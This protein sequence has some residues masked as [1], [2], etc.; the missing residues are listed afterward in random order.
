MNSEPE[1]L[2]RVPCPPGHYWRQFRIRVLP[3]L[4]F[5]GVLAITIWLWG[6]NL[7]NPLIV[8]QAESPQ[9]DVAS[10]KPGRILKLNVVLF[11][12]VKVGDVVAVIEIADPLVTSNTVAKILADMNLI[13]LSAGLDSAGRVSLADI[14]LKWMIQRADLAIA[15]ARFKWAQAQYERVSD[16]VA[17]KI[18]SPSLL[19]L[20]QRDRDEVAAEIE[21][22]TLAVKVADETFHAL[23]P[24]TADLESPVMK[25]TL[26]VAEQGLR[27]AEAQLAP[28][29]LTAPMAG[30]ISVLDKLTGS[31]VLAGAPIAT[32]SSSTPDRI[33]GFLGQPLR[34]DPKIGMKVEVRSRGLE[35]RTGAAQVLNIGPRVAL[36][37]ASVRVRGMGP[38]QERGLPVV[39]SVPPNM[40]LRPGELVDLRLV[41]N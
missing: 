17:E 37:D 20:A 11:Q 7:A 23:D 26:A 24:G 6:R 39:V 28:V 21:Q 40:L 10:P 4:G 19:D 2:P 32:I 35:R 1:A 14:H 41:V 3:S 36:L 34:V 22:K 38:A 15:K 5:L 25:A 27:L 30:R 16:L 13:R 29:I 8:G 33:T 12:E 31:I 9:V 18:S